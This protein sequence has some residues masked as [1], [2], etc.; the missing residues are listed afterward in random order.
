MDGDVEP[1]SEL[2]VG[3]KAVLVHKGVLVYIH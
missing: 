1:L 3:E 2:E